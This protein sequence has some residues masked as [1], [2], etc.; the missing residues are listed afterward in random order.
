LVLQ[1]EHLSPV[2][3]HF[4]YGQKAAYGEYKAMFHYANKLKLDCEEVRVP[5]FLFAD[6]PLTTREVV[7][8]ASQHASNY[9]PGRNMLFSA[10]GFSYASKY[11]LSPIMLGASPAPPES[12]FHDAK[13][14]FAA[15]FNVLARTGYPE[16]PP[17]LLMPLVSGDRE[18]YVRAALSRDPE[19]FMRSFT[20]YESTSDVECRRCVH[21]QQKAALAQR[22]GAAY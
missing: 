15:A 14:E 2:L 17:P 22:L 16:A 5:P 11:R 3:M 8:D 6:S 12:A 10:M 9:L 20:C 1:F 18:N 21:C 4:D 13:I 19:L 7:V